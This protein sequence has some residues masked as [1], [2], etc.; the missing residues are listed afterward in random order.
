MKNNTTMPKPPRD[1]TTLTPIQIDTELAELYEESERTSRRYEGCASSLRYL[2]GDHEMYHGRHKDWQLTEDEMTAKAQE[3]AQRDDY[4]GLQAA[5]QLSKLFEI[6]RE[7]QSLQDQTDPLNAE[8]QRRGWS[9]FFMVPGGH[10]HSSMDCSTCNR[11]G[12]ATRFGWLPQ[13]SG[14]TEADCV[15]DQGALLCTVCFPSAPT[16]WTNHYELEEARKKAEAC[17]GSGTY[18]DTSLKHRTGFYTGNWGTC[19]HC[20]DRV[21]AL[22]SGKLRKHK[23][24]A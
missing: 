15:A 16:E 11:Q 13:L 2:V 20:Q 7:I 8:F 23:P 21:T 1:L 3:M 19:P 22:A 18:V 24:A 9:R 5:R 4:E 6:R 17:P 10:I 12:R 14:R